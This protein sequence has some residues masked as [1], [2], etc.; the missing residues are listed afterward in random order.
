MT[1]SKVLLAGI[2]PII[3]LLLVLPSVAFA[4]N[5]TPYNE[6]DFD[7]LS[8]QVY[9]DK[10]DLHSLIIK[11]KILYDGQM[12]LG[13]VNINA[14]IIQ[15]DGTSI[16]VKSRIT[17][18]EIGQSKFIR[19]PTGVI[20][21]GQY[22]INVTMNPPAEPYLDH[23]FDTFTADHT[24]PENG[25][26][27]IV[28]AVLVEEKNSLVF[29]IENPL[30][31][32]YDEAIHAVINLPEIQGYESIAI[33]ND[34]KIIDS[35]STDIKEFYLTSGS[36]Y[37]NL[38][39]HLVENGNLFPLAFAQNSVQ[40]YVTTYRIEKDMCSSL[41]CLDVTVKKVEEGLTFEPWML[42][43]LSALVILYPIFHK[44]KKQ[45][46]TPHIEEPPSTQAI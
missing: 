26:E 42:L 19:I 31:V 23:I 37:R 20:Q 5:P 30:S 13:T 44:C 38:E 35:Y 22:T 14:E 34:N 33:I 36:G 28:D 46:G 4:D 25:F 29:T 12:P 43:G 21:E 11:P 40:D 9:Q 27:K 16:P 18:M 2:L 39:I 41:D 6:W 1:M 32:R 7:F 10:T 3:T 24:I 45:F 15:P 17:D 8:V